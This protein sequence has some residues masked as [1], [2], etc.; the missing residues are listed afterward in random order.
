MYILAKSK[1]IFSKNEGQK[2]D[3][4][5]QN[6][7]FKFGSVFVTK[8]LSFGWLFDLHRKP[9]T[10]S[11]FHCKSFHIIYLMKKTC[12]TRFPL[13]LRYLWVV[14]KKLRSLFDEFENCIILLLR[15]ARPG[16]SRAKCKLF[17]GNLPIFWTDMHL[18]YTFEEFGEILELK[19]TFQSF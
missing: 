5:F 17:V 2:S 13:C 12:N 1:C 4:I 14:L 6:S 8:I 3:T 11:S 16:G 18:K 19:V 10:K 9:C 15:F 7:Y